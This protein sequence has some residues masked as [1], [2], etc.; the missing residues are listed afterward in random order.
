MSKCNKA[1]CKDK[2]IMNPATL[3]LL[4]F[5]ASHSCTNVSLFNPLNTCTK[6]GFR[7]AIIWLVAVIERQKRAFHLF[8][9]SLH[10]VISPP[11]FFYLYQHLARFIASTTINETIVNHSFCNNH[12]Y[13]L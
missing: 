3:L 12:R 4:H 10:A 2:N 7:G 5:V 13:C 8:P 1:F 6:P 9:F 11:T